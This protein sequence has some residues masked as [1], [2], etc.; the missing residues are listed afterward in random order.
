MLISSPLQSVHSDVF[1]LK[2]YQR[3]QAIEHAFPL[4][5]KRY[6]ALSDNERRYFLAYEI[7]EMKAG[8]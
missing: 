6:L 2:L 7:I 3:L 1:H 5:A 4:Y 8:L